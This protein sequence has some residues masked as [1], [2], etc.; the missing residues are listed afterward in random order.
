VLEKLSSTTPVIMNA[1]AVIRETDTG[2]LKISIPKIA[3]PAAP[4]PVQT[5]YAVPIGRTFSDQAKSEKLPVAKTKNPI[6]GQ[7]FVK[8]FESFSMLAKPTSRKPAVMTASHAN[9]ATFLFLVRVLTSCSSGPCLNF[10]SQ[11]A[12]K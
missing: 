2:S 9:Y 10:L 3:V 11:I 12:E 6:L 5:A 7:I 1:I 4:I 8:L